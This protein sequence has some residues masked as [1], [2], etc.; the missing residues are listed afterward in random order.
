M[1]PPKQQRRSEYQR[2]IKT[3]TPQALAEFR[4]NQVAMPPVIPT[5]TELRPTHPKVANIQR[6]RGEGVNPPFNPPAGAGGHHPSHTWQ[7]TQCERSDTADPELILTY[8]RGDV[9]PS[10]ISEELPPILRRKP[11]GDAPTEAGCRRECTSGMTRH[12][13]PHLNEHA[14]YRLSTR[15]MN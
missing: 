15:T 1:A 3:V 9:D 12:A 13:T 11:C 7:F 6:S 8:H 2:E 14:P 5:G 4:G 10:R